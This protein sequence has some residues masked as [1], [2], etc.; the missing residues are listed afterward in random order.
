MGFGT[1][2]SDQTEAAR[3]VSEKARVQ[4]RIIRSMKLRKFIAVTQP[5]IRGMDQLP[6]Y[7]MQWN[8]CFASRG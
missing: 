4:G 5:Q 6:Q 2:K 3:D 7:G 8:A 1:L